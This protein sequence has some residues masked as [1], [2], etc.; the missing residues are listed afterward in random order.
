MM[1]SLPSTPPFAPTLLKRFTDLNLDQ[2]D[3]NAAHD[4]WLEEQSHLVEEVNT[5]EDKSR[6]G[7]RGITFA[8]QVEA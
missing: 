2:T 3:V 6:M 7:P 4:E 1:P 8:D 5:G